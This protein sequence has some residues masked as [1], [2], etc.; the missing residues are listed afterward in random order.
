MEYKLSVNFKHEILIIMSFI[1]EFLLDKV[2]HQ[3]VKLFINNLS[4]GIDN[5]Y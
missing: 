2:F 5:A 3:G 1:L 4:I